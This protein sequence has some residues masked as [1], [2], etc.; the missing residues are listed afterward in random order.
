[1]SQ[2]QEYQ[3]DL[4]TQKDHPLA[5]VTIS[6]E[7]KRGWSKRITVAGMDEVIRQLPLQG[8]HSVRDLEHIKDLT[9]ADE[10]FDEPGRIDLLLGQN[11]W[12]HLF[13]EGKAKGEEHQPE[14]WLTVFG[15]TILGTYDPNSQ[16]GSQ[17][18]ITY[19]V[20]P[21]EDDLMTDHL[22]TKFWK[23]EE[24]AV[25]EAAK[26]PSEIRVEEHYE[27]THSYD[28]SQKKY[29]VRLPRSEDKF[30]LGE[31]RTQALNRARANERSLIR[32]NKL[33][34]F[35]AVMKEYL[36]LGHAQ[37]VSVKKHQPAS[38]V[39][40][41]PVHAVFK[42]SSTTTKVRAV[43]YA[44]AKTT[45]HNSLND[46]LAVGPTLHPTLDQILIKF[47]SYAVAISGDITKMYREVLLHPDDRPLHRYIWREK[48]DADWQ[49]Y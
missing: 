44:S 43:F 34:Q 1:M 48:E 6:S 35:Q 16:T 32:K 47:R 2:L 21:K 20:S 4:H 33:P 39:Y 8:A 10:H 5:K 41:M 45:N 15:W 19:V 17:S 29:M 40:Y 9:L 7:F 28:S 14:A 26:T 31:S 36:D 3:Q 27:Q 42:D 11:V 38:E 23:I 18:A 13:L 25:Y 22:L 24:P 37:P 46:L 12:R 30:D 49:D